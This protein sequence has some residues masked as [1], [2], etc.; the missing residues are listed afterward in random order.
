MFNTIYY[1]YDVLSCL[2]RE[3]IK[4]AMNGFEKDQETSSQKL[5]IELSTEIRQ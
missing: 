1:L 3:R 4:M 5:R 2:S